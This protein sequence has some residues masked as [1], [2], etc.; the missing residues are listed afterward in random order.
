[1]KSLRI[2]TL[3][4]KWFETTEATNAWYVSEAKKLKDSKLDILVLPELYHTPY[5]PIEEGEKGFDWAIEKND[6]LVSEWQSIAKELNAVV[7]FPFFEKRA[8]GIYYNS[9]Y[10]FERD[11]SIAGLYRK[12]HIP[13]DPGF[14]EKYYFAPGDTGFEPIQTSAGKIGV[15]ICWDQWFPEAARINALKGADV[16]I[17]PTA[18]GWDCKEPVSLYERQKDSWMTVMRGHAIA[19]R[20]F[21]VAANRIGTEGDL[22]F[23]GHSFVS[24][25]D[26]YVIEDLKSDFLGASITEI[27]LS[28]IE[29][30]RRWWPHFRDRRTDLYKDILKTWDT[31]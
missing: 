2:A 10:V 15:L 19:N 25:P 31:P 11:G 6:A 4:G 22:T 29:F 3:Q 21:V 28:E 26:G 16:L 27:D 18:I 23:W 20:L 7:V 14:Y 12:S 13:D 8:R 24:A 9:A 30:N 17:Y 5:F 1:M